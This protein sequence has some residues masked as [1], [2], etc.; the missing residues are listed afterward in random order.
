MPKISKNPNFWGKFFRGARIF[1]ET[2]PAEVYLQQ[3]DE[4][5]Q[6][7]GKGPKSPEK[8]KN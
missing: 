6:P 1:L 5:R 2:L 7:Q 3:T 4:D 8:K